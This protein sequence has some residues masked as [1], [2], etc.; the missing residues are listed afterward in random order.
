MNLIL[1]SY[2]LPWFYLKISLKLL[3][4]SVLSDLIKYNM[5][6]NTFEQL[7]R[8]AVEALLQDEHYAKMANARSNGTI[9]AAK[10]SK[11]MEATKIQ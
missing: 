3:R 4:E 1:V 10:S 5:D 7:K 9:A 6:R 8:E 2:N 11:R